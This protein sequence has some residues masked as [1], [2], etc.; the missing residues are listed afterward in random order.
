MSIAHPGIGDRVF[1]RGAGL[2]AD[3]SRPWRPPGFFRRDL[4]RRCPSWRPPQSQR[5]R[6]R[7]ARRLVAVIIGNR[8]LGCVSRSDVQGVEPDADPDRQKA[9]ETSVHACAELYPLLR[10]RRGPASQGRDR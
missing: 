7:S 1:D 3:R 8:H 9:P 10:V 6:Q 5:R 4:K 2:L